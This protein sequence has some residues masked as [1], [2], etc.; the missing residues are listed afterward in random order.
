[1]PAPDSLN[2][3]VFLEPEEAWLG[4]GDIQATNKASSW[5]GTSAQLPSSCLPC[6]LG[7]LPTMDQGPG[8]WEGADSFALCLAFP[9]LSFIGNKTLT[10]ASSAL[11]RASARLFISPEMHTLVWPC[12]GVCS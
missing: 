4:V 11:V 8:F 1:M 12:V 5:T 7:R 3:F 10:V 6:A 2:K 9:V